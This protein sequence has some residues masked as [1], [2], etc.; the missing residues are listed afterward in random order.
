MRNSV[1]TRLPLLDHE[2]VEKMFSL[3]TKYK[4]IYTKFILK[5][6]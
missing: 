6:I 3:P 5:E 1:E 2:L 4:I